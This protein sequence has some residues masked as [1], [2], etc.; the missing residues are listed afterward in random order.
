MN[1]TPGHT[2]W[3]N[4]DG[5]FFIDRNKEVTISQN[6]LDK[7]IEL[8]GGVWL[9]FVHSGTSI[10]NNEKRINFDDAG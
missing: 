4:D 6:E 2:A 8:Q 7:L 10:R 9:I 3:Q 1:N 5:S